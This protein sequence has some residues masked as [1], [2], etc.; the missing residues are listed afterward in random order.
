MSIFQYPLP[1]SR[2]RDPYTSKLAGEHAAAR[3]NTFQDR[4]LSA[5]QAYPEGLTDEEAG[6]ISGLENTGY[7]KRCSDLRRKRLIEPTGTFR[8]SPNT[9]EP[10]RVCRI[11]QES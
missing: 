5:Y 3:A 10:Q 6:R 4:L 9:G 2:K 7:W 1:M 11:K 8:V